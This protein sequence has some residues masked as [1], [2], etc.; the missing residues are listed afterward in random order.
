MSTITADF[1]GTETAVAV[2]ERLTA[3]LTYWGFDPAS[4]TTWGD[5]RA[6]LNTLLSA[7]PL[8]EIAEGDPASAFRAKLN[9]LNFGV[10]AAL[11][12]GGVWGDDDEW[13]DT[14]EAFGLLT[15]E[16]WQDLG[17]WNDEAEA[18][19]LFAGGAWQDDGKW[20]DLSAA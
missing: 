15:G 9:Y 1:A 13:R 6:D 17:A 2:K 20:R 14:V 11:L 7:T 5:A 4:Y 18:H 19:A 3:I 8:G 10:R 16:T 12:S